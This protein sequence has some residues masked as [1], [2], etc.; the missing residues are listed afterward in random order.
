MRHYYFAFIFAFSFSF[1]FAFPVRASCN[2]KP[3]SKQ[4][5]DDIYS[6]STFGIS[7]PNLVVETG[8]LRQMSKD[9]IGLYGVSKKSSKKYYIG[10]YTEGT[11]IGIYQKIFSSYKKCDTLAK[12]KLRAMIAHEYVHHIDGSSYGLTKISRLIDTANYEKAA[13]VGEHALSKLVW[14]K[15]ITPTRNLTLHEKKAELITLRNYFMSR[16]GE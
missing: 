11:T 14:N 1:L 4:Y 16:K 10:A 6:Y 3:L 12:R 13:I 15:A 2:I 8:K 7:K 9:E 5:V